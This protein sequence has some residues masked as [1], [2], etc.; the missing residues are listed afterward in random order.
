MPQ[1]VER[2]LLLAVWRCVDGAG[3][4]VFLADVAIL[5]KLN[6]AQVDDNR[7]S[8]RGTVVDQVN[9]SGNPGAVQT[10]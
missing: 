8:C 6:L 5:T 2:G 9:R 4:D 7:V 1:S 3:A 10:Q